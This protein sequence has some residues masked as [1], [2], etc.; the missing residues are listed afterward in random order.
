MSL[1][2]KVAKNNASVDAPSV[3]N[4]PLFKVILDHTAW[5]E[6]VWKELPSSKRKSRISLTGKVP[7]S[8]SVLS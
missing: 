1:K 4:I 3:G 2:G 5:A 8:I 7:W 6:T